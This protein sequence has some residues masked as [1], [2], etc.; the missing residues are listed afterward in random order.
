MVDIYIPKLE[1]V[2][3][4][5][6]LFFNA[7]GAA[8]VSESCSVQGYCCDGVVMLSAEYR[9]VYFRVCRRFGS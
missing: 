9:R 8:F 7:G 2:R 1:P 3:T 4:R 6:Q 5:R